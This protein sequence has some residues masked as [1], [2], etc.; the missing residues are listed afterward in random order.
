LERV[1][2]VGTGRGLVDIVNGDARHVPFSDADFDVLVA[3]LWQV[4]R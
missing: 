1:L 3:V 2:D 4:R